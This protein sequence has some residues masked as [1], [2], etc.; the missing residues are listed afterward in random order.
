MFML[1]PYRR[2]VFK[3]P[4]FQAVVVLNSFSTVALNLFSTTDQYFRNFSSLTLHVPRNPFSY[5]GMGEQSSPEK[6][7]TPEKRGGC[8]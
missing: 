6:T 4:V 3:G 1:R 8:E 7:R 5:L 2:E